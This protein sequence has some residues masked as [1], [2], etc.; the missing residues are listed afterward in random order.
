MI[1]L[2]GASLN[3]YLH[4]REKDDISLSDD[5]QVSNRLISGKIVQIWNNRSE[6]LKTDFAIAGHLLSV[7]EEIFSNAVEDIT[8]ENIE[9][10]IGVAKKLFWTPNCNE[11]ATQDSVNRFR[12]QFNDF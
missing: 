9:K 5:F 1:F 2:C 12:D 3:I 11:Q 10:M 4:F 8:P 7:Q 6:K